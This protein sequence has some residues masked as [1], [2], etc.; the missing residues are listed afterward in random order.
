MDQAEKGDTERHVFYHHVRLND[1]FVPRALGPRGKR[2][3]SVYA[4]ETGEC[5]V[6]LKG[7]DE[8]PF[9]YPRWD[10]DSEMTYG[11]GPGYIALASA[12]THDLMENATLRA[13]QRA[14]DPVKMAPDRNVIPL[15]GTFRPGSVVYGAVSMSGQPLI[16]S[17]D[18]NGNIGLTEEEKRQKVETVKE[19][20]YYSIMSL[21]GRTGVSNEENRVIEEARLRN[22]APH[23]DRIMEEWAARKF[24]RR[25]RLLFKNG[26]IDPPPPG[27]PEGVPLQTRYQSQA[28]M[29]LRASE[30]QAVRT[31]FNDL[32]PLMQLKPEVRHRFSA[33]DYVEV[34]HEASPS[35][36]QRLLVSRE[37]A[38][39]AAQQE[40]QAAQAAQAAQMAREGGAGMR[41]MA[42][43]AQIMGAG[44]DGSS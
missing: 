16:R 26:Q 37:Q 39:A 14:A 5:V 11:I 8:M 2:Y 24:E 12:R 30:A 33:D 42:Q 43:A 10:V 7:Y 17:E 3:L 31:F 22:W 6:R 28:E 35:L 29:A 34:L 44:G 40:Q 18:F 15:N 1:Q 36:P 4:C 9:Y 41:D 27:T 38:A 25:Y 20:F 23:A 21:T 32:A 13:A 19:A